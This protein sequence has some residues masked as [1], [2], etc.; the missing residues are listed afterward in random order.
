[1][2]AKPDAIAYPPRGLGRLE[3]ARYL[4]LGPSTFDALVRN[5]KM[6]QSRQISDGRVVWDRLALDLYFDSLPSNDRGPSDFQ[7]YLQSRR[8]K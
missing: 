5:G 3:A 8:K 7:T 6:P 2:P 1:M 4:G